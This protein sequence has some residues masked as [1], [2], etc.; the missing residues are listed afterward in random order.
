MERMGKMKPSQYFEVAL[1]NQGV[2]E[3]SEFVESRMS[4]GKSKE[5]QLE[6]QFWTIRLILGILLIPALYFLFIHE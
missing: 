6:F 5:S 3:I 2:K 1:T 4:S